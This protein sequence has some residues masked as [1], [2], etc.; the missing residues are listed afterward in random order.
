MDGYIVGSMISA[1][2]IVGEQIQANSIK[3]ANL[4]IDVQKKI[5]SATDEETVRTLI[6]AG[7]DGFQVNI[8]NTYE[9]KADAISKINGVNNSIST[10]VGRVNSAESKITDTAITNTVKK[11]F[12]TKEET[13][14][15]IT[16][17]GYQTSSQVQQTVDNLQ[18]KFTE[19]G[20]Y[21]LLKNGKATLNTNFWASNGGGIAR[22]T[23]SVYK[24]CF[25]TSLPS[26][27]TCFIT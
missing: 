11:N 4:E 26:G 7:L 22:N 13:N 25:K 1:N 17:K 19:S 10:L 20:G 8:S 12:Y 5:T 14:N 24:T 9:T 2:S 23:D 15:Q 21:N 3:A 27:I 16:S 6:N 18:I